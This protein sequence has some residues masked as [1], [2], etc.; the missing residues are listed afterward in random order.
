M[1]LRTLVVDFP[2]PRAGWL[3]LAMASTLAG[4]LTITGSVRTSSWSSVR[5][6]KVFM[7]DFATISESVC[8]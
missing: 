1:L 5:L 8:Q 2:D 6:L 4:N 3:T 7:L